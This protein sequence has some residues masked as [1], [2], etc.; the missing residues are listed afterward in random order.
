[1]G[2]QRSGKRRLRAFYAQRNIWAAENG[3]GNPFSPSQEWGN[4]HWRAEHDGRRTARGKA[5]SYC[6]MRFRLPYRRD[7]QIYSGGAGADTGRGR[8]GFRIPLPEPGAGRGSDGNCYQPVRRDGRYT[9]GSQGGKSKRLSSAWHC[10]CSGKQH[11]ERSGQR[12]VYLGGTGDCGGDDQGIQRAACSII[13][14]CHEA[15]KGT[16]RHWR[17]PFWRASGRFKEAPQSNWAF[18]GTEGKNTALCQPVCRGKGYFLY[19]KRHWLCNFH[20][21]LPEVKGDLLCALGELSGGRAEAWSH[22]P[23]RG[24]HAC[25]S[26]FHTAG[27]LPENH[28]QYGGGKSK[29]RVCYGDYLRR[30]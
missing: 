24:R 2:C 5:D 9:C 8:C 19:R 6:G 29:G 20:G 28:Q 26:G 16:R 30:K 21:R 23:D 25:S 13:P 7:S 15:G 4:S 10:K 11:R 14:A 12:N 18:A 1:M 3:D 22:F 17:Q 27:A